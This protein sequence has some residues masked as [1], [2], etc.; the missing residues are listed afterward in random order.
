MLDFFKFYDKQLHISIS[1]IL[2][3]LMLSSS[4]SLGISYYYELSISTTLLVGISKEVYD[5][6]D[7]GK[8]DYLDI[9]ADVI[10]ILLGVLLYSIISYI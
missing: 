1:F 7:Y 8:F 4:N 3:L 10:G 6:F 5:Y 9:L 2:V